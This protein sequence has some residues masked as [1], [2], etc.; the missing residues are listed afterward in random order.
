MRQLDQGQGQKISSSC[1]SWKEILKDYGISKAHVDHTCRHSISRY[2]GQELC[3]Y[4]FEI[5]TTTYSSPNNFNWKLLNPLL[6]TAA[7]GY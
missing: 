1:C 7:A 4:F 3:E 5:H 6:V 2:Y